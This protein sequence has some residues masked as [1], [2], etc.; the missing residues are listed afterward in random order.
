MP[1]ALITINAVTGSNPPNGTALA[2][3]T[4]VSLDNVNTGG[5]VS[6]FWEF[7][8]RP[9][10]SAAAFSA[11]AV[12][13]PTFTPDVEGT[14]L[15][16]LTVNAALATEAVDTVIAAI[17]QM[18][19]G[20]R[21][22]AAGETTEESTSRGWAEDINTG[23]QLLDNLRADPGYITGYSAAA[24]ARGRILRISSM[25]LIKSGLPGEEYIPLFNTALATNAAHMVLPL[26]IAM[27]LIDGGTSILANNIF[28]ARAH[29]ICGP[30]VTLG[31]VAG[32]RVYVSDTATLSLT[33][34]TN[35]RRV[36][37]IAYTDG[38]SYDWIYF[39][40]GTVHGESTLYLEDGSE[41]VQR[42][43]PMSINNADAGKPIDITSTG[44]GD[45]TI[46]AGNDLFLVTS[47]DMSVTT[48]D[49]ITLSAGA[50]AVTFGL[51]GGAAT[52]T[53]G[54][55]AR[56]V[57]GI[58]TPLASTDAAN[59]DYVDSGVTAANVTGYVF[60][61]NTATPNVSTECAIDPGFGNRTAPLSASSHPALPIT[62]SG[63]IRD[64]EIAAVTGPA[65]ASLDFTV[66]LNGAPSA[67]TC[68]LAIAGTAASDH[69]NSF[70]VV[71][72][73]LIELR[74]KSVGVITA[75][76]VDVSAMLRIAGS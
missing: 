35:P 25:Q 38:V 51:D 13:N 61:G 8:D 12:Q 49:D 75:G 48:T 54:P 60:F 41:I 2:I 17:A 67:I 9:A 43:G 1:Q 70:A 46:T 4:V 72:G 64:L 69:A 65:G 62:K 50:G 36:G 15:I 45:I 57:S 42:K 26:Y 34:G 71:A 56:V 59:K 66:W 31:G 55:T 3:N 23:L 28:Y 39:D 27:N 14:Y 52:A 5:E 40:G 21:I 33:P 76:A 37:T 63:T 73:D 6:Y 47:D 30:V 7:L 22:P 18:K 10:G 74:A 24:F 53:F 58:A 32:D 29:G 11:A 19:S 44:A 68:T 16:R 20:I